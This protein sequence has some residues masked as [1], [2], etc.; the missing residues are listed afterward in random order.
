MLISGIQT[1]WFSYT[2][3]HASTHVHIFFSIVGYYKILN[4]VPCAIQYDLV[5]YL[6][7]TEYCVSAHLK[8][9]I[10][11]SSLELCFSHWQDRQVLGNFENKNNKCSWEGKQLLMH[12]S[13]LLSALRIPFFE[14]NGERRQPHQPPRTFDESSS[15][16]GVQKVGRGVHSTDGLVLEPPHRLL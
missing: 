2:Y 14:M 1:K 10:Y 13:S 11:P 3:K 5:V 7:Y 16:S 15:R 6:F 4:I 12:S 9:L 8:L